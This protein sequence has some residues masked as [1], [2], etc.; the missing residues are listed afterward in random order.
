MP[1]V[2]HKHKTILC[3]IVVVIVIVMPLLYV[4]DVFDDME[5]IFMLFIV[6]NCCGINCD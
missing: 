6:N 2:K 4:Y 3:T 1:A 5:S